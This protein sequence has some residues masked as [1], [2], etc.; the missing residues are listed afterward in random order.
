MSPVRIKPSHFRIVASDCGNS[1]TSN[2]AGATGKD[3]P[4]ANQAVVG[5]ARKAV[6]IRMKKYWKERKKGKRK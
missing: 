3:G 1:A 4:E 5:G 2:R 6:S